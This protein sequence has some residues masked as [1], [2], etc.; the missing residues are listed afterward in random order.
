[1]VRYLTQTQNKTETLALSNITNLHLGEIAAV[2]AAADRFRPISLDE[3]DSVK[4]R[5]IFQTA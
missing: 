2:A 3:M 1:M 5:C 4:F